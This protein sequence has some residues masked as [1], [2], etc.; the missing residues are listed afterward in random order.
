MVQDIK[1]EKERGREED[2]GRER[3]T[4]REWERTRIRENTAV[5][6]VQQLLVRSLSPY[7]SCSICKPQR[8]AYSK[9]ITKRFSSPGG[10]WNRVLSGNT[11]EYER[12]CSN[13]KRVVKVH[14]KN[15]QISYQCSVSLSSLFFF[16]IR[17]IRS[18]VILFYPPLSICQLQFHTDLRA[19]VENCFRYSRH[20]WLLKPNSGF[21]TLYW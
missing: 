1:T 2:R 15:V 20:S 10:W 13:R 21:I 19:T 14:V 6:A 3:E 12:N 9:A 7:S 4:E 5:T 18:L 17:W 11:V 16:I 8:I